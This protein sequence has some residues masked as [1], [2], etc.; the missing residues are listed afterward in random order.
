VFCELIG[1]ISPANESE[2][3]DL[4]TATRSRPLSPF[5]EPSRSWS[6]RGT[7]GFFHYERDRELDVVIGVGL[8]D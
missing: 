6:I 5:D 2:A 8:V 1:R 3:V 7:T 4:E